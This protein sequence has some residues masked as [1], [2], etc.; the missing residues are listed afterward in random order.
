VA[1][2]FR[3]RPQRNSGSAYNN[4]NWGLSPAVALNEMARRTGLLGIE[5]LRS[6]GPVGV[7]SPDGR[8]SRRAFR[9]TV[10]ALFGTSRIAVDQVAP[11]QRGDFKRSSVDLAAMLSGRD[12]GYQP[13]LM[14]WGDVSVSD[15]IATTPDLMVLAPPGCFGSFNS[16]MTWR[17]EQSHGSDI[18]D[19][20][21]YRRQYVGG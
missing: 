21:F 19:N 20:G 15:A 5:N 10:E 1:D 12:L 8:Q 18:S 4:R 9:Q 3:D 6:W 16:I 2:E 11:R 13:P 14:R 17:L 7:P